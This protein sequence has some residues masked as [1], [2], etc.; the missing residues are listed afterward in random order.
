MSLDAYDE[1]YEAQLN[2]EGYNR[3]PH[4]I[5]TENYYLWCKGWKD[6][7]FDMRHSIG[8]RDGA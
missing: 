7:D 5:G 2:D 3:N 8:V 6:A 1:G 4:Q